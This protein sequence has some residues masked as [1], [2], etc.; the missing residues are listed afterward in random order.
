MLNPTTKDV[1]IGSILND[2]MGE[3]AKKKLAK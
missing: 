3:G 1:I 2:T